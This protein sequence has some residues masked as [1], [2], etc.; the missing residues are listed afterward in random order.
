[1]GI[2]EVDVTIDVTSIMSTL[3]ATAASLGGLLWGI[4]TY[5][6]GQISQ[7]KDIIFPLIKEFDESKEMITANKILN[8]YFHRLNT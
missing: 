1:L 2:A 5:R 6:Q 8:V 7:R 4:H 3:I